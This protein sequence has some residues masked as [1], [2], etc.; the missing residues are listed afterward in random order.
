VAKSSLRQRLSSTVSTNPQRTARRVWRTMTPAARD[1]RA[2]QVLEQ[3]WKRVAPLYG[4]AGQPMPTTSIA[5]TGGSG[6]ASTDGR[7]TL[8][9]GTI[10]WLAK[11]RILAPGYRADAQRIA[12][13]EWAHHFQDP[14]LLEDPNQNH[15][16]EAAELFATYF[17]H[18]LFGATGM[19]KGPL[20]YA[21]R[22]EA[23]RD[24][25]GTYGHGYWRRGQFQSY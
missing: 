14:A 6:T 19:G 1:A 5:D 9:P 25:A 2:Q 21:D 16:E 11:P 3:T 4:E 12:L 18:K 13:H 17:G 15:K 23:S 8:S 24:L 20:P 22:P 10:A 7:V